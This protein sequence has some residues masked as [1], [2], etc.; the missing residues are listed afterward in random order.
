MRSDLNLTAVVINK[1]NDDLSTTLSIA[2]F[3]AGSAAKVWRYSGA[4][5]SA[6]VAQADAPVASGAIATVFPANSV[7]M[8]VIP[9]ASYP[10]AKPIVTAV[11]SAASYGTS[12]APG[13]MVAVW[14][15][16]MGPAKLVGLQQDTTG[17]VTT[18]TGGVR[19]LFDGIPAPMV[20][21]SATQCS[22]VVPYFG[23][24]KS[25]THVQV[26]YQGVRSDALEVPVAATAP[27]LFTS[28]QTGTGQGAIL[29]ADGITA[30][31]VVHPAH[32]GEVV[33]L[34][35]TGEGLTNPPGVDGRPAVDV[36]PKPLAAVTVKIGGLDATVQYA[37]AAPGNIPGLIQ[38]NVVVPTGVAVG[39]SVP[40]SVTIG[41]ST[42]QSGVTLAVQ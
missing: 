10:V 37:G 19:I 36:L 26:E 16:N 9:P 20:Y 29:N 22:A 5:L 33:V 35:G 28:S 42:S 17:M 11:T 31:S 15:T 13:Q 39:S 32:P 41:S 23:A 30:N 21:A 40:V 12:I 3:D 25:T 4:Q 14:G 7:T 1:T 2:N 27:A 34:W 18:S 38:I 24:A 6:I 8:L